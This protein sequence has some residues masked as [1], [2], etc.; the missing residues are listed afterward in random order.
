MREL[1]ATA[2]RLRQVRRAYDEFLMR[3]ALD[4]LI[5][6]RDVLRRVTADAATEHEPDVRRPDE[7][8]W[9]GLYRGSVLDD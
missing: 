1:A 6:Q 9:S 4:C 8:D 3:W 2:Q 5:A 7:C